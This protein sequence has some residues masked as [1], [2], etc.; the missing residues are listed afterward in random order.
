MK[1]SHLLL[2]ST[3]SESVVNDFMKYNEVLNIY[4]TSGRDAKL[5][6]KSAL[7][8]L[9]F[10]MVRKVWD[11]VSNSASGTLHFCI[12]GINE[13]NPFSH[14]ILKNEVFVYAS[15]VDFKVAGKIPSL[16]NPR[17]SMTSD[18]RV[19]EDCLSLLNGRE[20]ILIDFNGSMAFLDTF[21]EQ[22]LCEVRN[23]IKGAFVSG[24]VLAGVPPATMPPSKGF[25]N[26][27]SCATMNQLYAPSRTAKFF[28]L[29]A[30]CNV[31]V[32][33]ITN[34]EVGD[35]LAGGIDRRS[36]P[37]IPFLRANGINS[38]P[39]FEMASL[40][41]NSRYAPPVK[42]FDYYTALAL[43]TFMDPSTDVMSYSTARLFFDDV[44]GLS[45]VS[46]IKY[47]WGDAVETYA[48]QVPMAARYVGNEDA[49]ESE[50]KLL[51]TLKPKY[52]TVWALK[53]TGHPGKLSI[54][55]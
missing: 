29:M 13:I 1:Y 50:M 21:W 6:L 22:K 31:P 16:A 24:G 37:W 35:L 39:L 3:P 7:T 2:G 46:D 34:N 19:K 42:A 38:A 33:M 23:V 15:L 44:Y 30:V 49:F 28:S 45:L 47:T 14:S 20:R 36:S 40:F 10:S 54:T 4:G 18:L 9:A 53:F 43:T 41:Y 25:L 48:K 11:S 51:S 5:V 52:I 32:Y 27:L 8:A 17:D 12:G 55:D 26:R